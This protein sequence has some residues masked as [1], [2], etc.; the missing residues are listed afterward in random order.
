MNTGRKKEIRLFLK[1]T[2]LL[3]NYQGVFVVN[4]DIV[5]TYSFDKVESDTVGSNNTFLEFQIYSSEIT[6]NLNRRYETL[7]ELIAVLGGITKSFTII[8][9]ILI[10]ILYDWNISEL[11]MDSLFLI[12]SNNNKKKLLIKLNRLHT[13]PVYSQSIKGDRHV[14]SDSNELNPKSNQERN[15]MEKIESKNGNEKS[16]D[17]T[18]FSDH[19]K[20]SF[21]KKIAMF[22]KKK[23]KRTQKEDL[24]LNFLRKCDEKLDLIHILRKLEEVDRLKLILLNPDQIKLFNSLSKKFIFLENTAIQKHQNSKFSFDLKE[25]GSQEVIRIKS[26]KEKISEKAGINEIDE[27]LI[28]LIKLW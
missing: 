2:T 18:K 21:F 14:V 20:F 6:T 26:L 17:S 3:T 11:I 7:Y 16:I 10:K 4:E 25:L 28:S 9:T 12:L 5:E 13:D 24:Y 19:L 8:C 23:E 15:L 1:K 27:R 22:V